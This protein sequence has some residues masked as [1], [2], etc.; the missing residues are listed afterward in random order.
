[1]IHNAATPVDSLVPYVNNAR[2]HSAEQVSQVAAS[3]REFGF[4]NPI[5]IDEQ[6]SIIA[7]HGRLAAARKLGMDTVPTIQLEGLSEAQKKAYVIADNSLALNAGWDYELLTLEIDDLKIEGFDID[8][9]GIDTDIF[10]MPDTDYSDANNELDVDGYEDEMDMKFTF[11]KDQ[12]ERVNT[13]LRK[14]GSS[15]EIA[16]MAVLNV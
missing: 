9:L 5:L 10:E 16:L 6:H 14:H 2:T 4:T 7:G 3:I 13:E 12:Y 8:L 1:M 15:K 11:S